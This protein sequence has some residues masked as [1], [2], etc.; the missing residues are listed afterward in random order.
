MKKIREK[1]RGPRMENDKEKETIF[2]VKGKEEDTFATVIEMN[3]MMNDVSYLC[4]NGDLVWENLLSHFLSHF[5]KTFDGLY[6]MDEASMTIA[7]E[8]MRKKVIDAYLYEL[9]KQNLIEV[10]VD[11]NG[12]FVY[13]L[14]E[15]G[16]SL[17]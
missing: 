1:E 6:A 16:R 15:Q 14:S 17:L 5:K 12:E 10:K 2:I 4:E 3:G 7:L 9:Y 13:S 11:S 8:S